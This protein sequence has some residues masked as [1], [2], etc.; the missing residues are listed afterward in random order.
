[1]LDDAADE[2]V[3]DQDKVVADGPGT[4]YIETRDPG[5]MVRSVRRA[6]RNLLLLGISTCMPYM[7]TCEPDGD[8]DYLQLAWHYRSHSL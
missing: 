4:L 2:V 6:G 8:L 1:M 3:H 5:E 7:S